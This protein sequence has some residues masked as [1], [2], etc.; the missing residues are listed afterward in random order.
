MKKTIKNLTFWCAAVV[1][2]ELIFHLVV[3]RAL[4][5]R[6]FW[7]LPFSLSLGV[8]FTALSGAWPWKRG[9]RITAFFLMAAM[10]FVFSVQTVYNYIFET[11]LSMTLVGEGG[12]AIANFFGVAV[13]GT[14]RCIPYILLYFMPIPVYEV[15]RRRGI[16]SDGGSG[17]YGVTVMLCVS[18]LTFSL[19][20]PGETDGTERAAAYHD[21]TATISDQAEEFGLVTAERLELGRLGSDDTGLDA[22]VID[23][24]GGGTDEPD[25]DDGDEPSAETVKYNVIDELDFEKLTQAADTEQRKELSRYFSGLTGTKQNDYTGLFQGF[26]LI[27]ICAESYCSYVV[28][29]ELTP[30]LYKLTHEGIVF[31]NFYCSFNATTTNGEYSLNMGLLPDLNRMSFNMSVD[32]YLPMTLAHRFQ[33][34]GVKALAYHNN[35][36]Y[37]Y[38]RNNSHPN[39]GFEF[40]A[41]DMGLELEDG[42]PRS[43]LEMFEKT[44]DE[45]IHE[46]RFFAYYMTYSGHNPYDPEANLMASKNMDKVAGLA[47]PDKVK[48]YLAANLELE[49]GLEYLLD[50]LEEAGVADKTVIVLTGDHYPYALS[51]EEHLA[52]AGEGA[53]S[54]PFWRY[55]NNFVCWTGALEEPICVQSPCCS[56]DILPTLLNLF[57]FRYDSRLLTG[58]DVLSDSTHIAVLQ[59]GSFRTKDMLYDADTGRVTYFTP[60][61]MLS[62]GYAQRLIQAVKNQFS[63]SAA[64]LRSDY[65][66]F[67]WETLGLTEE[68]SEEFSNVIFSDL[69]GKWYKDSVNSLALRGFVWGD[70]LSYNGDRPMGRADFAVMIERVF[71]LPFQETDRFPF[72]DIPPEHYSYKSVTALWAAGIVDE[73]ELFLPYSTVTY[74]EARV[75]ADRLGA[76][77]GVSDSV[78]LS[79][80]LDETRKLDVENGGGGE[81]MTR[82]SAAVFINAAM[83]AVEEQGGSVDME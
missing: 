77:L 17:V 50:R 59:T 54:D 78:D 24:T 58:T 12:K 20:V 19:G 43:D 22:D 39:M 69:E 80:I 51:K 74:E 75:M 8:F 52:L 45:Y 7:S 55:K 49:Y 46:D 4:T 9:N 76:C 25:Q 56:Q 73:G 34:Q 30:A 66:G 41:V 33:T 31:D 81:N 47:Y 38:G 63:V 70:Q 26:N 67:A 15:L 5:V 61:D 29:P 83:E 48:A 23:L 71:D 6:F 11:L 13:D 27:E 2:W 36:G 35:T 53:D 40:K 68:R 16:L 62:D 64:V 14:L 79:K 44:V 28:D 3:W 57:G 18:V 82:G 21:M 32:N 42:F 72:T 65:Y 10:A 60:E 37:Y 1:M